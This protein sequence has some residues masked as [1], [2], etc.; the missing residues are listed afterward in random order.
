MSFAEFC[1]KAEPRRVCCGVNDENDRDESVLGNVTEEDDREANVDDENGAVTK[2]DEDD[3]CNNLVI[4]EEDNV[5][6]EMTVTGEYVCGSI[7]KLVIIVGQVFS[8]VLF[9]RFVRL[10]CLKYAIISFKAREK[11]KLKKAYQKVESNFL[12]WAITLQWRMAE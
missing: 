6:V 10:V 4:V 1:A 3:D 2:D 9:R 8:C 7:R 5:T 12:F 11:L